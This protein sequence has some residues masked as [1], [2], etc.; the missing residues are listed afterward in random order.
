MRSFNMTVA[1]VLALSASAQAASPIVD[2]ERKVGRYAPERSASA[3]KTLCVC[4][5]D[6]GPLGA[7]GRL[8]RERQNGQSTKLVRVY[9]EVPVFGPDDRVQ[10]LHACREFGTLAK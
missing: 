7:A 6:E 4:Q 8:V 3:A 9:C 1:I 5:D 10:S 2:F